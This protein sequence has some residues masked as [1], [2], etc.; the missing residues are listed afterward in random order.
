MKYK[1]SKIKKRKK[2]KQMDFYHP[3]LNQWIPS[4]IHIDRKKYE[5]KKKQCGKCQKISVKDKIY[6][7]KI[8][9]DICFD[10]YYYLKTCS[11]ENKY[12][13]ECNEAGVCEHFK[14]TSTDL[15]SK[16]KEIGLP[17]L[18]D[19]CTY[20]TI[21]LH[22]FIHFMHRDNYSCVMEDWDSMYQSQHVHAKNEIHYLIYLILCCDP[23][24]KAL[25]KEI[26]DFTLCPPLRKNGICGFE[27]KEAKD[28]W[29][30]RI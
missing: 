26:R 6:K 29:E 17:L 24:R 4:Q 5:K 21:W 9:S 18:V 23:D 12:H 30:K 14:C 16:A 13:T 8:E 27:Y 3:L 7:F 22:Y 1:K 2:I 28:S 25:M 19:L 11:S 20:H 15:L 10:V